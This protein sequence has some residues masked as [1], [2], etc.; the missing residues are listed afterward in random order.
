MTDID[1]ALVEGQ[2]FREV[3]KDVKGQ[4]IEGRKAGR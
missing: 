2:R 3:V 1:R 4:D